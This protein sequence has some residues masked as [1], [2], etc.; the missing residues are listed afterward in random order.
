M[1]H[2]IPLLDSEPD[3][4]FD[5]RLWHLQPVYNRFWQHYHSLMSTTELSCVTEHAAY[6]EESQ[7][8]CCQM[9]SEAGNPCDIAG[10]PCCCQMYEQMP[11]RCC[12][13]YAQAPHHPQRSQ[14]RQR[15]RN[16]VQMRYNVS[17]TCHP[18]VGCLIFKLM[19]YCNPFTYIIISLHSTSF[20]DYTIF[21]IIL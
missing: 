1:I 16:W 6:A 4:S 11:Q 10:P 17:R 13:M 5:V 8:P 20:T 18:L 7:Q 3:T 15:K 2:L 9:H 12:Q 14:V 21:T 19:L